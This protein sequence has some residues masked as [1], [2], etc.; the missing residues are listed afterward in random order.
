MYG[1]V[2]LAR[3]IVGAFYV[4]HLQLLL[5][6]GGDLGGGVEEVAGAAVELFARVVYSGRNLFQVHSMVRSILGTC[7]SSFAM[8]AIWAVALSR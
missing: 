4:R 1:Y 8:A 2:F 3:F 6:D 7:S 5:C